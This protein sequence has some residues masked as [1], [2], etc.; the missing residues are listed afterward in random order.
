MATIRFSWDNLIWRSG[1]TFDGGTVDSALPLTNLAEY[2]PSKKTRLTDMTD[3]F[4]RITQPY[5]TPYDVIAVLDH[6]GSPH[7]NLLQYS[8]DVDGNVTE[9]PLTNS[10]ITFSTLVTDVTTHNL[11][12]FSCET[13]GSVRHSVENARTLAAFTTDRTT[14]AAQTFVTEMIFRQVA[15]DRHAGIHLIGTG[16]NSL[17]A[18]LNL[19]TG[20]V[21]LL[22]TSGNW[23]NEV[24]T[25]TDLT[26]GYYKL[27]VALTI[28]KDETVITY[29]PIALDASLSTP[30]DSGGTVDWFYFAA[31]SLKRV[32]A[33]ESYDDTSDSDGASGALWRVKQSWVAITPTSTTHAGSRWLNMAQS[34]DPKPL[35]DG[36]GTLSCYTIQDPA[37]MK[38]TLIE[39]HDPDNV[40]TNID[41]GALWLGRSFQPTGSLQPGWRLFVDEDTGMLNLSGELH[42]PSAADY[43]E[44][45]V[46]LALNARV[47][48]QAKQ[49]SPGGQEFRADSLPVIVIVDSDEPAHGQQQMVYGFVDKWDL[50]HFSGPDQFIVSFLIRGLRA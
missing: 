38:H 9:W 46:P 3:S 24:A 20:V 50:H 22:A 18:N 29:R 6:N 32:D 15:V 11:E 19:N 31:P 4:I 10:S 48:S 30:F 7:R 21:A 36:L 26:G 27:S 42:Y 2:H 23:S 1:V 13:V 25:V 16:S 40:V 34:S 8:G 41:I 49:I 14:A 33:S 35:R 43:Y 12:K 5:I 17:V 44:D 37:S 39:F 45:A 47:S 28:D